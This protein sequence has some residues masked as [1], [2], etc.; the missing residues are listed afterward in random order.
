MKN[1]SL[2]AIK[3]LKSI[4]DHQSEKPKQ[5]PLH[6]LFSDQFM[7][8]YTDFSTIERLSQLGGVNIGPKGSLLVKDMKQLNQLVQKRTVFGNWS[9]MVARAGREYFGVR[10]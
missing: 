4:L 2:N 1:V 7:S 9:E 6:E 3:E 8:K 5:A 10:R